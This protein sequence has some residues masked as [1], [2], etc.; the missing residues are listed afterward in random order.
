MRIPRQLK[1]SYL[2]V[3]SSLSFL[4]NGLPQRILMAPAVLLSSA[5]AALL[6]QTKTV[7]TAMKKAKKFMDKAIE[8]SDDLEVGHG[9][10]PIKHFYKYWK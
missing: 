9:H 1:T 4:P 3:K 7:K 2:T 6:P 10:G 5:I 8:G